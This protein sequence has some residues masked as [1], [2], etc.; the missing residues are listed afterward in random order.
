LLNKISLAFLLFLSLITSFSY[1]QRDSDLV[2]SSSVN[3]VPNDRQMRVE[4]DGDGN[5]QYVGYAPREEST[6][7]DAWTIF[8]YTYTSGSVTR[9]QVAFD[10]WDNRATASY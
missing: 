10:S 1:A 6:S 4:Y 2:N 9:K 5:A 7:S 3:V 8:K